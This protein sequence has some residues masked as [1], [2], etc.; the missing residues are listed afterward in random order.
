M[1]E[2][3]LPNDVI[4]FRDGKRE[5]APHVAAMIGL[6]QIDPV[7]FTYEEAMAKV[8]NAVLRSRLN[9]MGSEFKLGHFR[10]RA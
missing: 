6:A 3:L 4:E 7:E 5:V 10:V 8:D 2:E 9:T 1:I